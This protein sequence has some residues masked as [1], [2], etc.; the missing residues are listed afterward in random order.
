MHRVT[1]VLCAVV[2]MVGE[3]VAPPTAQRQAHAL[4]LDQPYVVCHTFALDAHERRLATSQCDPR[5]SKC[6]IGDCLPVPC[7]LPYAD[8][9]KPMFPTPPT[10]IARHCGAG[11]PRS[12][13]T[14]RSAA[15]E[16]HVTITSLSPHTPNLDSPSDLIPCC[17]GPV[18]ARPGPGV[19][20]YVN[21]TTCRALDIALADPLHPC[22]PEASLPPPFPAVPD[23]VRPL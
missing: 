7:P 2:D 18:T 17:L 21:P 4:M 8:P 14:Q 5:S 9:G 12:F 3:N 22:G 23:P 20:V 15:C 13:A 1:P 19:G 16:F 10:R 6:P 11:P